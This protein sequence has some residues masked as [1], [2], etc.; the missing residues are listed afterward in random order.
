MNKPF[1]EKDINTL[2]RLHHEL[3][4]KTVKNDLRDN[5]PLLKILTPLEL[6]V[7]SVLA[8][9][10]SAKPSDIANSIATAKSTLTNVL[11]RL[12]KRG[13]IYRAISQKDRRSFE[14]RLTET[15]QDAQRQHI[16]SEHMLYLKIL[17]ALDT[18]E[19]V[20]SFLEILQ[21]IISVF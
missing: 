4:Y 15:G 14:L 7:I 16:E 20:K 9:N 10:P 19:E 13:Y 2:N 17:G 1:D 18:N 8:D 21:K 5:Y 12:E 6:S 11:D 3:Y